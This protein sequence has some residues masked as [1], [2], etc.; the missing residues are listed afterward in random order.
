MRRLINLLR[1]KIKNIIR[2]LFCKLATY[3]NFIIAPYNDSSFNKQH[4][5]HLTLIHLQEKFDRN[6]PLFL[7]ELHYMFFE[8]AF[9]IT[10]NSEITYFELLTDAKVVFPNAAVIFNNNRL[11]LHLSQE[12]GYAFNKHSLLTGLHLNYPFRLNGFSIL[13][14]GPDATNNYFHWMTDAIPKLA[15]A[16][17]AGYNISDFNFFIVNNTDNAFQKQSL[18]KMGIPDFAIVSLK[19]RKNIICDK[20]LASSPTCLSGNVSPWIVKFLR[21]VFSSWMS[22]SKL[23]PTKI[24]ISRKN[25]ASRRLT[26]ENEIIELLEKQGFKNVILEE[27]SLKEQVALFYNAECVI[28][29]HGAGFTNIIFCKPDTQ[30]IEL[31]PNS[32]VNQCYWT[33]ASINKMRYGYLV[34]KGEYHLN[35]DNNLQKSDFTILIN[36]IYDLQSVFKEASK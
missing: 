31:F 28:G 22:F 27:L 3:N 20:I 25:A 14:A 21:D 17:K 13:L 24:F 18:E 29:S 36:D 5:D 23:S 32:Y 6:Q 8:S 15:I 7:G 26:N 19:E 35:G 12:I 9:G 4:V 30:I 10:P 2:P 1:N 34:S 16:Q 33:I 11:A